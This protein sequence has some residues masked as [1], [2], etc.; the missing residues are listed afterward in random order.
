MVETASRR[1]ASYPP[2]ARTI[3]MK[4]LLI[5]AFVVALGVAAASAQTASAPT[6]TDTPAASAATQTP[7]EVRAQCKSDAKAQGLKGDARKAAVQDCFAKARPD[8]AKAQQCR[9]EGKAKGLAKKELKAYVEQCK[10]AG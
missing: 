6:P 3:A 8:L 4:R 2:N 9:Q 5:A 1:V 7:K 10:A